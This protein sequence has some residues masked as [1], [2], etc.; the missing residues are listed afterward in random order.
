MILSLQG[1][2][3]GPRVP[4]QPAGSVFTPGSA[5][6]VRDSE[7]ETEAFTRMG[8]GKGSWLRREAP[9][10]EG[11]VLVGEGGALTQD[12]EGEGLVS[13]L[14]GQTR[15]TLDQVLSKSGWD[16]SRCGDQ[17]GRVPGCRVADDG[18]WGSG[19]SGQ[20]MDVGQIRCVGQG[21]RRSPHC[22]GEG[23]MVGVLSQGMERVNWPGRRSR[24]LWGVVGWAVWHQ[25]PSLL[26]APTGAKV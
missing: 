18:G 5:C 10:A 14:F 12:V 6:R 23:C 24:S 4:P 16:G 8:P 7:Q 22:R 1:F 11:Q 9:A 25:C 20:I 13:R 19:C 17:E 2:E 21:K 26:F 15:V 3:V